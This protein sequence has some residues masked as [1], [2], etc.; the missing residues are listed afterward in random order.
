MKTAIQITLMMNQYDDLTLSKGGGIVAS[1]FLHAKI[2][3]VITK[4]DSIRERNKNRPLETRLRLTAYIQE[5]GVC[6]ISSKKRHE[7]ILKEIYW[8]YIKTKVIITCYDMLR[9]RRLESL[10]N[11]KYLPLSI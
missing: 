7:G 3:R 5:H 1:L 4:T 8:S 6:A 2:S 11:R 10:P 9:Q